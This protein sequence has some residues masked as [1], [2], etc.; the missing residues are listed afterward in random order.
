MNILQ[1]IFRRAKSAYIQIGNSESGGI[2]YSNE[3]LINEIADRIATQVSKLTPQVI[4]KDNSGVVIKNDRLARMLA[5]R[6]CRELNT[7][8]WL[9]KITHTAVRKGDGFAVLVYNDDFTEI[10]EI[11][12]IDCSSYRIFESDGELLFR[13]TWAF[14]GKE[15]TVPY[16]IVIHLKDRPAK[17]RFL[18]GNPYDD[19]STSIDML[20]TTY[21]GIKNVVK[22]SAQLRG[23][24]KFNNWIDDDDLKVKIKEFQ[25]AYMTSQNEGGLAGIGSEWEFKELTQA[26][27]QIPTSQ[28]EFFKENLR[29]YFGISKDIISGNYDEAKW[30]AFYE[31]KIEVIAIKL[32]LEFTYKVFN[33]RQRGFGNRIKF[34]ADR[35]QYATAS[36]RLTIATALFDR[37][38]ITLNRMLEIMDEPTLGEEGEVRMISLNYVKVTDQSLYQTGKDDGDA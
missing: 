25:S 19:L 13:F 17:K 36:T 12:V 8:D 33:E 28:M 9:Y 24:L 22:N 30:N 21:E 35:L 2:Y 31:S 3:E 5:L 15:Y 16:Q 4:R 34:V 26:P 32:S 38:G 11:P 1:K 23:Y 37:G 20:N 14:N 7:V 18:G 6:P 27:K 10:K 29:D